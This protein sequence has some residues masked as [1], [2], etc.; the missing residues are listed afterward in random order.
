MYIAYGGKVGYLALRLLPFLVT[1]GQESTSKPPQAIC[2][3][4]ALI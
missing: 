3:T 2:K 4:L 1:V